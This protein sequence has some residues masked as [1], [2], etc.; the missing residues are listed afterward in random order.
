[1]PSD[2][3][4]KALYAFSDAHLGCGTPND[5][6]VKLNTIARLFELV[7]RD[8]DHL[9]ILGD[10][11]DFWFEFGFPIPP[12]HNRI[13]GMLRDLRTAGI[14]IDYVCGNHDFWM[15][16]YFPDTLGIAIHRDA[17]DLVRGGKRIHFIHGDGLAPTDHGYRL[18]KAVFRNKFC[19]RL[20]SMLPHHFATSLAKRVSHASRRSNP[21]RDYRFA[22]DYEQYAR[23]QWAIHDF[24]LLGHLHLPV[25][26]AEGDKR[27]VNTGDFM[28][29]FTFARLVGGRLTLEKMPSGPVA[30]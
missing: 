27:Y 3:P 5:E 21:G 13:L 6:D 25:D 23:A 14:R 1:M 4:S 2:T 19:I 24:V 29:H 8:G 12:E 26:I 30:E 18:M 20:Y 9:I 22:P 17:F 11:F 15:D 16:R 10:L 7:K 28:S